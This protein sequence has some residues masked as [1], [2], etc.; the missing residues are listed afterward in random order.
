[1][2]R[3]A[4][5]R[6]DKLPD[7]TAH[8]TAVCEYEC[9]HVLCSASDFGVIHEVLRQVWTPKVQG[10]LRCM[11]PG[12]PV[13]RGGYVVDIEGI[14]AVASPRVPHVEEKI[15][16]ENAPAPAPPPKMAPPFHLCGA[17]A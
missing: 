11:L 2:A 13:H 14:L 15:R 10:V 5:Q 6:S 7:P 9:C 8:A 1:M 4:Q 12:V 17:H 16:S 3:F